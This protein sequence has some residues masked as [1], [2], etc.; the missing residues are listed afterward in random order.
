M[1]PWLTLVSYGDPIRHWFDY[2]VKNSHPNVNKTELQPPPRWPT[3]RRLRH[4]PNRS[5]IQRNDTNKRTPKAIAAAISPRPEIKRKECT[6]PRT[7][8][9]SSPRIAKPGVAE[10]FGDFCEFIAIV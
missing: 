3:R 5:S 6:Q 4:V 1:G 2:H 7:P 8:V 9:I 10:F